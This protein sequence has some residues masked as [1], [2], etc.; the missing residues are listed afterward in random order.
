[1]NT[2]RTALALL[3]LFLLVGLAPLARA[4]ERASFDA[5]LIAASN[6]PGQTDR[7]LGPYEGNLKRVL[8]FAKYRQVGEGG[9]SLN[10]PGQG[11]IRLGRGHAL[12]LEADEGKG[13]KVSVRVNWV[14][15][16]DSF[17]NTGVSLAPGGVTVL[18][19]AAGDGDEVLAV[20]LIRR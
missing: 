6:E 18:G 13:G 4:A 10:V 16:G 15:N 14:I 9:T 2:R 20:I 7:R 19:G 8:R 12:E 17:Q 11:Q 5:I 1:M 3:A